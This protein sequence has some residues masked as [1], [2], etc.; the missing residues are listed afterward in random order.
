MTPSPCARPATSSP[1]CSDPSSPPATA[2]NANSS[3]PPTAPR[4][5]RRSGSRRRATR[6]SA[7]QR[8][9]VPGALANRVYYLASRAAFDIE[10][11]GEEAALALTAP[12][13]PETPPLTSEAFLFDLTP[14]DL[15]EVKIWRNKRVKGVETGERELVPYFFTRGLR[16]NRALPPR[17]RRSSST[18]STR[19]R[20]RTCGGSSSHSP[21]ATSDPQPPGRSPPTSTR[22]T[23]SRRRVS[24][25][26]PQ[27]TASG[28]RSRLRSATGSPSTG[29]GRSS[30]GGGP[31]GCA[32]RTPRGGGPADPRRSDDRRH[33]VPLNLHP[34]RH[35]RGDRRRR[36][37]AA[38]SVSKK[39]DY[40][41]AGENA[42][43]KLE[44]AES[45]G[46]PSST[47]TGSA[48]C[49][50]PGTSSEGILTDSEARSRLAAEAATEERHRRGQVVGQ[51][52]LE[53]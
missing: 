38:S 51:L 1:R 53:E 52:R 26:S 16:R 6:T 36:R 15:A 10:A 49:S 50:R 28:R 5:A 20:T 13:E 43:S 48:P 23:R 35:Q 18:N 31:R 34:R 12:A 9:L 46:C 8:P 3:C 11:L 22:S 19:P 40:V 14:E 25:S 32:W 21:S 4:A 30:T 2:Q 29:T 42:G 24:R 45:S 17:T 33:R 41:V 37:K 39:T 44:K 7:R 27:S 47:R